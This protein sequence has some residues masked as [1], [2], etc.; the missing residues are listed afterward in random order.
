MDNGYDYRARATMP[1]FNMDQ[2]LQAH[3]CRLAVAA[4]PAV[5]PQDSAIKMATV[6]A[7]L[8]QFTKY[9]ADGPTIKRPDRL[10]WH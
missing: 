1:A 7:L 3:F 6:Q 9:P 4:Q 2:N 8:I 10:T 5:K